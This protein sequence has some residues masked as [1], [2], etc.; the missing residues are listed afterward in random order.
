MKYG[1]STVEKEDWMEFGFIECFVFCF[2]FCSACLFCTAFHHP[3]KIPKDIMK[4]KEKLLEI[5]SCTSNTRI[6]VKGKVR[7]N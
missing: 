4:I 3:F 1:I 7:I 2:A 5:V 6:L